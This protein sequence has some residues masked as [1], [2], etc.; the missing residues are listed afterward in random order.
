V[1]VKTTEEDAAAAGHSVEQA[2]WWSLFDQ[3]TGRIAGRFARVEPRRTARSFLLGLL[4]GIERKNCWNLAEHAGLADPQPMQ[5]LLRE[6]AWDADAVRDDVRDLVVEHLG[7]PSAV[8]VVDETGFLKKGEHSVAVQRQYTGTAGRIENAQVAVFLA[9]ACPAG[10]ALVDR[11]I[12]LPASWCADRER[13]TAAGVP[14]QTGFSTKPRL[15]L[16]MIE[17]ARAAGVPASFVAGDEVYGN[18][19]ALREGIKAVGLGYV[20]AVACDHRIT[21]HGRIRRRLDQIAADL[22][23]GV[24]QRYSAG[25][26]S[27]GPR[28]YDWAWIDA[29]NDA[30]VGHSAL[31]RRNNAT[32]ELAY[33]RCYSPAPTTLGALIK[34]AGARWMVEEC[35]QSAKG[36]VGLDHYQVRG[37]TP[38]HR[39][40]TLTMLALAF[41]AIAA[42]HNGPPHQPVHETANGRAPLRLTVPE[43]RRLFTALGDT[44][45]RSRDHLLHWSAWRTRHQSRAQAAHYRRRLGIRPTPQITN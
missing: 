44:I 17:Q 31:I 39:H 40:V 30:G 8:L 18:D 41:L 38:W 36:Q 7:T 11:R 28:Y 33:Y 22:P 12:Y 15:A 23:R 4:S 5:R 35:F 43:I 32:G 21:V 37:W 3:V 34:V 2:G 20:L 1:F 19:P 25:R 45:N 29:E 10:R 13:C 14:E 16:E 24:W 9:Y 6:A 27:K 26:G 42:A